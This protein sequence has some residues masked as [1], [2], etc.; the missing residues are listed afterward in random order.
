MV[1][2]ILTVFGVM[3]FAFL[4]FRAIPGDIA[5]PYVGQKATQQQR[6]DWLNRHGYDRPMV[7]NIHRRLV[8]TDHTK[9]DKPFAARDRAGAPADALALFGQKGQGAKDQEQSQ[10]K[11]L[12]RYVWRLAKDTPIAKLT[13]NRFLAK[14]APV[15]KEAKEPLPTAKAL[16]TAKR[17]FAEET[18]LEPIEPFVPL[19]P[20]K[21]KSGK[22]VHAWAFETDCDPGAIQSNTF[23]MEWP[24]R[25]GR[26]QE[27]P[28]ID[29]AEFF[30]V[31][32]AKRKI[33]PAQARL[34]DELQQT[35]SK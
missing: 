28:E 14:M 6:A 8:I 23:T 5:A 9:G 7:L 2:S 4:M 27:F 1:L 29:Q 24:P 31:E 25:S 20:V 13:G 34:I 33:N 16:E 35:L 22:I 10:Q 32:N 3:I 17:E 21:Q 11:L 15:A 26:Q 19:G 18:G 30:S 12:G